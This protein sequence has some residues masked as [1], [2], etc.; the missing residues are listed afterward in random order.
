MDPEKVLNEGYSAAGA[1]KNLILKLFSLYILHTYN[2]QN[3]KI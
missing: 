3:A 1:I 2:K